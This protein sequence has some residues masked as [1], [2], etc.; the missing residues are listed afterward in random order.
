CCFKIRG[1]GEVKTISPMELNRMIKI[2]FI[3]SI[4]ATIIGKFEF[5]SYISIQMYI[6]GV[7]CLYFMHTGF[8]KHLLEEF[9]A[10]FDNQVLIFSVILFI[11]LLAPLILGRFKIPGIIGL[12]IAG[13]II[14]PHGFNL[15]KKDSA[16]DL[17]S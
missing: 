14:G 2:F 11:I 3:R 13:V 12:I 1:T 9:H 16:I 10:P 5:L 6:F 8:L 15:I 17:F 4:D 7:Y